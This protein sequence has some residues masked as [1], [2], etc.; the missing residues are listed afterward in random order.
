MPKCI[1]FKIFL[2]TEN[3]ILAIKIANILFL[4]KVLNIVKI[5]N[6]CEIPRSEDGVKFIIII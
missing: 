4:V 2:Y 6:L 1:N 5:T 3:P